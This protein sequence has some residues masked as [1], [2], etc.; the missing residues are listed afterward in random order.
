VLGLTGETI[1]SVGSLSAPEAGSGLQPD[2]LGAYESVQLPVDRVRS[3][4]EKFAYQCPWL[5][6]DAALREQLA[7]AAWP[8]FSG[9]YAAGAVTTSG[10]LA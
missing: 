1:R 10:A 5:T 4:Q 7:A 9:A 3:S 6:T 2:H 8:L